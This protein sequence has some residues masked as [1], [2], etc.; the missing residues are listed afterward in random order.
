[1]TELEQVSGIQVQQL[2]AALRCAAPP[3]SIQ[4][5][6]AVCDFLRFSALGT[7]TPDASHHRLRWKCDCHAW[8]LEPALVSVRDRTHAVV[9]RAGC[10]LPSPRA[11][12]VCRP[13]RP[14]EGGQGVAFKLQA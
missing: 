5:L 13:R 4:L 11:I 12:A 8:L 7:Q 3:R 1:M 2:T 9:Q 14:V 6:T 10:V